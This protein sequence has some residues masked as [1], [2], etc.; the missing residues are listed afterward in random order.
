MTCMTV[1]RIVR[2]PLTGLLLSCF[3]LIFPGFS[4]LPAQILP[5]RNYTVDNGLASNRVLSIM[6][7]S[8]G[9]MWFGT[10]NGISRFDGRQFISYFNQESLDPQKGTYQMLQDRRGRLWFCVQN[11]LARLENGEWR[12][13]TTGDGLAANYG[14]VLYEDRRGWIWFATDKGL[15]CYDNQGWRSYTVREG[16]AGNDLNRGASAVDRKGR[17]WFGSTEGLTV[18]D[19]AIEAF[20]ANGPRVHITRASMIGPDSSFSDGA[21]LKYFENDLRFDFIGLD[22]SSP[23]QVVYSYRLDGVKGGWKKTRLNSVNF[24]NL[25]PGRHVFEVV[26]G[27]RRGLENPALSRFAFTIRPAFYQTL[28]FRLFLLFA[29]TA[30]ILLLVRYWHRKKIT[31]ELREKNTQLEREIVERERIGDELRESEQHLRDILD[32]LPDATFAVDTEGKV[33]LWN[34]AMEEMTGVR[35]EDILLKGNYEYALPIYGIRRPLLVDMVLKW[36]DE[37]AKKYQNVRIEPGKVIL[38]EIDATILGKDVTLFGKA[39]PLYNTKGEVIGAIESIRDISERKQAERKLQEERQRLANIIEGTNAGTWEWNVQTG[40]TVFNERW[41]EIVGYKLEEVSPVS[42]KTWERFTHPDDLRNTYAV[43]QKHFNGESG[44]YEAE[45]RMKH[46]DG[47]W[48]WV[49]DRGKVTTW[50]EDGKPLL[51]QGTHTDITGRKRAEEALLKRMV[52]ERLLSKISSGA[53]NV[54]DLQAFLQECMALIGETTGASRAYIFEDHPA[55]DASSNTVEW[56][57]EGTP[58]QKEELQN[59]PNSTSPWGIDTLKSGHS[60]AY[61]DIEDIQEASLRDFLRSYGTRSLLVVPLFVGGTYYGFMGFDECQSK[62]DWPDEDVELLLSISRIITGAMER[63]HASTEIKANMR[64]TEALLQIGSMTGATLKEI[65]DFALEKALEITQSKIGYLAF[66]N[67]DESEL[68]INSWSKSALDECAVD[69]RPVIYPVVDTGLWG[70]AVRQR[71]PVITNDYSAENPWKKGIPEGHVSLLR[72]MNTPVLENKRIVVVAGV[73]NK[74]DE[75]NEEDCRQLT[76]LMQGM[77]HLIER[78]RTE[79]AMKLTQFAMDKASEHILWIGEKGNILYANDSSCESLGYTREELLKMTVHDIDPDYTPDDMKRHVKELPEI[80]FMIFES[81]HKARDGRIF[82]VEVMANYCDNNG[83]FMNCAFDRDITERKRAEQQLKESEEKFRLISEQSLM[84]I[85]ILQDDC[86]R[87]ANQAAADQT[88][89]TVEEL[90]ELGPGEFLQTIHPDD[91]KFVRDQKSRKQAGREGAITHYFFKGIRK[92]GETLW[93]DQ[94]SRTIL[95]EGRTADLIVRADITEIKNAERALRESEERFRMIIEASKDGMIAINKKGLITIF[96]PAAE[97]IFGRASREM[98]DQPFGLLMPESLREDHRGYVTSFFE[99][100]EPDRIIDRTL[101]LKALHGDGTEFDI[102]LSLSRGV[103]DGEEFVL[104]VIRDITDKLALEASLLQSRKMETIGQLAGGV[105]HDFNNMLS[106]I[107]G[108]AEVALAQVNPEHKLQFV[109]KE[110]LTAAERSADLTRQLLAFARKQTISPRVLDL[111]KTV[112]DT[113]GMLRRMI[114]EAIELNWLPAVDILPVKM[115]PSQ[116]DQILT[117]LCINA[118]DAIAGVG[119]ISISTGTIAITEADC[120]GQ[121]GFQPGSYVFLTVSDN[122]RGMEKETLARVFEPFFTTKERGKGTGLGLATVYGIVKQNEGFIDVYSELEKGTAFKIYLPV[123]SEPGGSAS[124]EETARYK[125]TGGNE[126]V[127][128]VEDETSILVMAAAM[129]ER[130]G[131]KVLSAS[132]PKEAIRL[133]DEHKGKIDLL[134]TDVVMPEMNGWDLAKEILA[135]C[136]DIRQL[137]MSGYTADVI[138]HHGALE[139]GVH[140]LQKPFTARILLEKV[141]LA[142][143]SMQ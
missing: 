51:M 33:I 22:Y 117:N 142:L 109:L 111:N 26:A 124:H 55:A 100:G 45:F 88:G 29:L 129:L 84:A 110:I 43:L 143:D 132:A 82:P 120:A 108:H 41:A 113:L 133:A 77:W 116:I 62:R 20:H 126:T 37:A 123:Y 96:N 6:Q 135:L 70:E 5:F 17:L 140:F 54:D 71:R 85:F 107:I 121:P 114:G 46:K 95:Y 127:L 48:V 25:P 4:S 32:F 58:S 137:F 60:I 99:K 106:V 42:I 52:Y 12:V 63:K 122:G 119:K 134:L 92:S 23:E 31:R 61:S 131:Y 7:D 56:C 35:A 39:K 68:T 34:K 118:R 57:A 73:A 21:V 66:V 14:A 72:H 36:D 69:D 78:K 130:Q 91:R 87:Y 19:P 86:I 89:Y 24:V 138:A 27:N 16:L 141:R 75:Y 80:G 13:F 47:R 104:A 76:L 65:T 83:R 101:Q 74:E 10:L 115:D 49:L 136:P 44:Y 79:D 50:T 102:E 3:S 125:A 112:A 81:R 105:A 98:L 67:E 94:Y 90:L 38:A 40:E 9:F 18:F 103:A 30:F 93:L 8:S 139:T 97:K 2:I 128:L 59:I 64:R 1:R 15:N 28:A 11:G 53:V